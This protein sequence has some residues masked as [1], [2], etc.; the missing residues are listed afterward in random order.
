MKLTTRSRY[1]TRMLLDIAMHGTE[2]PV[3]IRDIAKRQGISVKYLEK[4][5]RVLRKAGYIR[6]TLGAHGG[7]QLTQPA[8][9]IPVGDVVFALE[10]SL[11]PYTC[12]EENP[13]C[14]RMAVCLTRTIWDEAS[15]AM[16][17]KLNSFTLADL[18]RDASL[19]PKNACHISPHAQD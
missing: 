7:Y 14:P 9:E 17:K 8:S 4:L 2:A 15:R 1:G 6:S 10:E 5:I 3:S 11:A 12:D 13:C 19:C 16:Y 18:M